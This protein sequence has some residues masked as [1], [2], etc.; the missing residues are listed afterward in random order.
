M[1]ESFIEIHAT[2]WWIYMNLFTTKTIT[3]IPILWGSLY[4]FRI[5]Q[6]KSMTINTSWH[7]IDSSHHSIYG[8]GVPKDNHTN[9]I[10]ILV[11]VYQTC[12]VNTSFEGRNISRILRNKCQDLINYIVRGQYF[13]ENPNS[14]RYLKTYIRYE[15]YSIIFMILTNV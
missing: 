10:Q 7:T 9:I 1:Y 2:W 5:Q 15:L 4:W 3:K 11:F 8:N 14:I 6:M 13:R 12:E